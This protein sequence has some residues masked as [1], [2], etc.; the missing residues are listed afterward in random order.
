LI[1][2]TT[3]SSTGPR[4]QHP[5]SPVSNGESLIKDVYDSLRASP[6]WNQTLFIVTY[7]EHGGFYDHVS[8]PMNGI[9]NPDGKYDS[10]HNFN[11]DRLGVRV[12]TVMMSP[13]IEASTVV[14]EPSSAH[15]DHTS[16]MHTFRK[17]FPDLPSKPLTQREAWSATYESVLN[18]PV[19]SGPRACPA[20]LE[21]PASKRAAHA[22]YVQQARVAPTAENLE[23][24]FVRVVRDAPINSPPVDD[25][26]QINSL[27]FQMAMLAANLGET[28]DAFDP[29]SVA[30]MTVFQAALFV[31]A[32]LGDYRYATKHLLD[33]IIDLPY[34][35][36]DAPSGSRK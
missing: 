3:A 16:H 14:H 29:I 12:P 11:Y 20:T 17:L 33:T 30:N 35:M 21:L 26:P 4:D 13:W 8:P 36:A 32:R 24:E 19:S 6:Q 2:V 18:R 34:E 1:P 22:R 9:P 7:D 28:Q 15:F 27:Q 5:P 10:E 25:S 23:A 31:R